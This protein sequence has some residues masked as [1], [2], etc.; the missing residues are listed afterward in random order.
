MLVY[1]ATRLRRC[2]IRSV[3]ARPAA[4]R[5]VH[6]VF[7][8]V[9]TDTPASRRVRL[10]PR[11]WRT[12]TLRSVR[13]SAADGRPAIEPIGVTLM[14]R[15]SRIS[16]RGSAA[17]PTRNGPLSGWRAPAAGAR[18]GAPGASVGH[19]ATA[20]R[21]GSSRRS[22]RAPTPARSIC[23]LRRSIGSTGGFTPS[24]IRHR[25]VPTGSHLPGQRKD[26]LLDDGGAAGVARAACIQ[27]CG[28]RGLAQ[29]NRSHLHASEVKVRSRSDTLA[30]NG[31]AVEGSVAQEHLQR[32]DL[33]RARAD[34]LNDVAGRVL[35]RRTRPVAAR[36]PR[37]CQIANIGNC[38]VKAARAFDGILLWQSW[39]CGKCLSTEKKINRCAACG[40]GAADGWRS[41]VS[42]AAVAW[43]A[44]NRP[45]GTERNS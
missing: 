31:R 25:T 40:C 19:A 3:A 36:R 17:T 23:V 1:T 33:E 18:S 41:G 4:R 12:T 29:K 26:G 13:R 10:R 9:F 5:S 37:N 7:D 39:Q 8:K 30:R 6:R 21:P 43:T 42:G 14:R 27:R 11:S 35:K 2:P 34:A 16:R 44:G 20:A 28:A 32:L 22:S 15:C 38:N 24:G 45:T